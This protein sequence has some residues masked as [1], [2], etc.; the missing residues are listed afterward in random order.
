M[1]TADQDESELGLIHSKF[2][3]A[4]RRG[5]LSCQSAKPEPLKGNTTGLAPGNPLPFHSRSPCRLQPSLSAVG[6]SS[7]SDSSTTLAS[8]ILSSSH[9]PSKPSF[10]TSEIFR[11]DSA[12]RER[13][14]CGAISEEEEVFSPGLST[15][16]SR[17]FE[18]P[19]VILD[20]PA[21]T[22]NSLH[23]SHQE[24]SQNLQIPME[25]KNHLSLASA[26]VAMLPTT[27]SIESAQALFGISSSPISPLTPNTP[28]SPSPQFS[29]QIFQ[30]GLLAELYRR[31]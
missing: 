25:T 16:S 2:W 11:F 13:Y 15:T 8:S 5:S 14:L 4:K 7:S 10:H 23:L 31:K 17:S 9:T 18:S 28:L 12:D 29:D 21:I 1:D 6:T 27:T 22:I 19:L 3:K 20:S 24:S 30:Q 26:G